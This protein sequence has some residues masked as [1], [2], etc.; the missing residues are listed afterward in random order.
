M[1]PHDAF[2]GAFGRGQ[3][4]AMSPNAAVSRT[5]LATPA[6]I[7][8]TGPVTGGVAVQLGLR[9]DFKPFQIVSKSFVAPVSVKSF[10]TC[11][12]INASNTFDRRVVP[13]WSHSMLMLMLPGKRPPAGT[14]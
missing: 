1:S 12:S 4:A 2:G 14:P 3:M 7:V 11:L 8:P 10:T 9:V 13:S 5:V 6:P